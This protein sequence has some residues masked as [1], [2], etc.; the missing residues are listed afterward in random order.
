MLV[1]TEAS[2]DLLGAEL[3]RALRARLAP[4]GVRLVGVGGARMAAEGIASPFPI[5]DLAI[6][7][8]F[9]GLPALPRI[10][11]RVGQAADLA[12]REQPDAAVLIDS[13]GFSVR[14][15]RSLRALTP[16]PLLVKYVLP[17]VWAS[18]PRRARPIA[19]LFDRLLAIHAFDVP[20]YER[21]GGAVSFVG[22]PAL[23]RDFRG[24]DPDRLRARIGA[25]E[26]DPILLI[27]PGSRPSEV[28]RLMGPFKAAAILLARE[29]P[30][31]RLLAAPAPGVAA[32]VKAALADWPLAV[33]V[34]EDDEARFDAMRAA[35]VAL[36]CS[37]T[38]TTE[39]AMAGSPMVV[40]YRLGP[41][42]HLIAKRLVTTPFI[43]LINV[44]AERMV[45][46]E[47]VQDECAGPPLAAAIAALLD[48][49]ARRAAQVTAQT[50]ALDILRGGIPDPIAAA[51]AAIIESLRLKPSL[52]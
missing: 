48:D 50:A 27:L 41:L 12:R 30:A 51:A 4:E 3:A 11:R 7:G 18:R 8:V 37:G 38:V 13:W 32:A 25:A 35:T 42:S 24:A 45:A 23:A 39:L 14:L 52:P 28:A 44:A 21:E 6:V 31:L 26:D 46:P 2:G 17:Q 15:A 22:N 10:L 19:R 29:R 47:F 36:A 43:T 1:A 33:T 9:D 34:V 5:D 49:P 20:F 40:A 16:R